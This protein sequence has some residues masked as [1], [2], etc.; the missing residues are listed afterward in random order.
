MTMFTIKNI[1]NGEKF[2]VDYDAA[3]K[4]LQKLPEP[5]RKQVEEIIKE[6]KGPV[7]VGNELAYELSFFGKMKCGHWEHLQIPAAW[8]VPG[9]TEKEN[10]DRVCTMCTCNFGK[11]GA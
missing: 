6:L 2:S 5:D 9:E 7:G 4:E 11:K 3:E 1:P 10:T 8:Y